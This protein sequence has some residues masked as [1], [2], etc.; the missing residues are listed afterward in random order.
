MA[1]ALR[2]H[3]QGVF[4]QRPVDERLMEQWIQD[5]RPPAVPPPDSEAWR[6]RRRHVQAALEHSPNSARGPDGLSFAAWRRLG[7]LAVDVLWQALWAV[8][9]QQDPEGFADFIATFNCSLVDQ[10]DFHT[11]LLIGHCES[12]N[13]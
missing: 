10:L 7:P 1:D 5:D 11:A 12:L 4:S 8:T 13:A 3:W 9:Q 2:Q 6:L